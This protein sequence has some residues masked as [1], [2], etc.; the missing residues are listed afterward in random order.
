EDP[1]DAVPVG[2]RVQ[3]AHG[4]GGEGDVVAVLVR[5]AG[6]GLHADAGG[7]ARQH[8]LRDTAAAQLDIET[9]AVEGTPVALGDG[10]VAGV[11]GQFGDHDV[12]AL[13][14]GAARAGDLG[15]AGNRV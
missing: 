1:L 8:D 15:A 4:V 7:D 5:G 10:D 13:R 11:T 2:L 3:V 12:P 9:G 14:E 6:G